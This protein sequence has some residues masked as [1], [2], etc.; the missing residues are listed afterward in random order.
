MKR[1]R[2]NTVPIGVHVCQ[3]MFEVSLLTCMLPGSDCFCCL[4]CRF[5]TG[6]PYLY[7]PEAFEHLTSD[8]MHQDL[9]ADF[10]M[11]AYAPL[12]LTS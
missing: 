8:A 10:S 12:A 4:L 3:D 2:G 6:N 11:P 5:V 1:E 9:G 7:L